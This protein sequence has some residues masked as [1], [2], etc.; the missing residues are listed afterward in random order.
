M[1]VEVIRSKTR[2]K[3]PL[4]KR[5]EFALE[6]YRGD[7]EEQHQFLAYPAMDA[8]GLN[9]TLSAARHPERAIEGMVRSIRKMLADDDGTPLG[10]RPTRY[11]EPQPD[12]TDDAP[13]TAADSAQQFRAEN[14]LPW[15]DGPE[16]TDLDAEDGAERAYQERHGA[17]PTGDA[18]EPDDVEDADL[19]DPDLL[20]LDPDGK[21]ITGEQAA[22][23]MRFENGSS[24]RRFAFL[25]DEDE[26]LTLELDQLQAVFKKLLAQVSDRPTRR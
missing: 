12:A 20:F 16:P 4:R 10:W 5:W 14:R 9:H 23:A 1:A 11:V 25:M 8:G 21:P 3:G 18:P 6:F 2:K 7:A 15:V 22:Q 26:E 17:E 19:E 24:R 13:V